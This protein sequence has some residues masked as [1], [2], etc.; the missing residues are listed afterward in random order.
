M[1]DVQ[2]WLVERTYTDKGL[3]T[4][5]YATPDGERRFRRQRSANA[6]R[7]TGGVTAAI[8]ADPDDL[9]P[10]EDPETRERYADEAARM[11]ADRDPDETV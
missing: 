2:L 7:Q 5:V 1:D 9:H 11:A 6:L 3:V 4:L 10:V 8:T